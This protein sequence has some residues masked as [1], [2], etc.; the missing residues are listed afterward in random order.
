MGMWSPAT[1]DKRSELSASAHDG[2]PSNY[3]K[4]LCFM[5]AFNDTCRRRALYWA[6]RA[7]YW[8]GLAA[9]YRN[10]AG[11]RGATIQMYHSVPGPHVEPWIDPR[12]AIAPAQFDAQ[13]RFLR[14]HRNVIPYSKLIELLEREENP[15]A[16][17]V[18]ITFDDGYLDTFRVAAPIL[19]RYQLPA[20][21]FISTRLVQRGEAQC[22]DQ[23]FSMFMSNT[24]DR[25]ELPSL[26]IRANLARPRIKADIYETLSRWFISATA[27]KRRRTLALLEEQL[28]PAVK[29][30]RLTMTWHDVRELL[31]Q[32]PN[33]EL[34]V[35][36]AEH[37]D[38][39]VHDVSVVRHELQTC[40]SDFEREL[41]R[42]PDHFA[43]PYNRVT[44]KS[45]ELVRHS[46]FRSAVAS[47]SRVLIS[48]ASDRLALPRIEACRSQTLFRFRTS[49]AY[50]GLSMFLLRRA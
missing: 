1:P 27:E 7:F 37:I 20:I 21:L 22:G 29:P 45:R 13:M 31:R 26:G 2:P 49:G 43:F 23:L 42:R 4:R 34:G 3:M 12:Y 28:Q 18:V 40:I 6:H 14:C 25:L 36:G 11:V 47:G 17:T 16:G 8:S 44:P 32:Y 35:H 39:S 50:P 5:S 38:L 24:Q 41:G 30:P 15:S 10:A 48:C 19:A 33:M 9:A 46:G